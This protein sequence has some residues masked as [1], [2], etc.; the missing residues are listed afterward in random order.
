MWYKRIH[1][2]ETR[3]LKSIENGVWKMNCCIVIGLQNVKDRLRSGGVDA[4][5]NVDIAAARPLVARLVALDES[6][7]LVPGR[8]DHHDVQPSK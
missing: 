6:A 8:R 4:T 7:Q 2:I 1:A 5:Y 3:N